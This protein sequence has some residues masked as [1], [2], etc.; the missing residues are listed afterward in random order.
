MKMRRFW[1]HF[2]RP[3][4]QKAGAVR[5]SVHFGGQCMIVK[6]VHCDVACRSH[7]GKRQPRAVMRGWCRNVIVVKEVAVI[8]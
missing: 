3:A 6:D 7:A 8:L 1:F 4:S 5:W 2:N